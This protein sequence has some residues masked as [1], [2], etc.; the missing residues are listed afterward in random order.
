MG[1]R[2]RT[3][4]TWKKG[5]SGNPTGTR[6]SGAYLT[7]NELRKNV[8]GMY[9]EY[10]RKQMAEDLQS[11]TP[12]DRLKYWAL[13]L[14]VIIPKHAQHVPSEVRQLIIQDARTIQTDQP[15][16]SRLLAGVGGGDN[17]SNGHDE[18]F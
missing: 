1:K 2:P 9:G 8:Y 13:L 4:G 15:R 14:T 18:D 7:L 5:Q 12:E 6:N 11:L 3:E 17:G 10:T 16:V